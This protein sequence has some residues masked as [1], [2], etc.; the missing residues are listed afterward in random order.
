MMNL[1]ILTWAARYTH[2]HAYARLASHQAHV[3]G[4]LLVRPDGSTYQAV[5][6]DRDTGKIVFIGTHQGL[7]DA[8][9][10]ARGE[11][12][13]LY[14]FAQTAIDLHDRSLLAIAQRIAQ[15]VSEHLPTGGVP[16]GTTAPDR[17]R[18]STSRPG[19]SPQRECS[20]SHSPAGG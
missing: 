20:I 3:I 1:A 17:A 13:G 12:W 9:T 15:Y 4:S 19:R 7:S 18:R 14:G 10:W 16:S 6:F 11:G 8:S 2:R 5:H